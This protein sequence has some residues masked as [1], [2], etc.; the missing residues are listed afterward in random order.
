MSAQDSENIKDASTADVQVGAPKFVMQRV[1][2]A[3]NLFH[4][5]AEGRGVTTAPVATPSKPT[6]PDVANLGN[7]D[8]A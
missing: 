6:Q 8:A 1:L 7:D 3:A 4:T 2:S 5:E